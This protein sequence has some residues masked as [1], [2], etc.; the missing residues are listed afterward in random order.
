MNQSSD[1]SES[2]RLGLYVGALNSE[3]RQKYGI[4]EDADGVVIVDINPTGAAAKR[5]LREGDIIKRIDKRRIES[6][7]DVKEAIKVSRDAGKK[8]NP[9]AD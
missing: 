8:I 3:N 6:P 5:G 1:T 4:D 2:G 7:D 9:A